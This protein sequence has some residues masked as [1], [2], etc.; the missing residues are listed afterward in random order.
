MVLKRI[1][2]ISAGKVSGLLYALVGLIAGA[3]FTVLSLFG[4]LAGA[5]ASEELAP[6]FLGLVF[7]LGAVIILPI[8][9]GAMGFF[10]G[11]ISA[12]LYNLIAGLFGGLELELEQG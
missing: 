9:Y 11:V 5:I 7:G 2:V 12:A 3:I 10:G 8:F 1:G 4:A 6:A